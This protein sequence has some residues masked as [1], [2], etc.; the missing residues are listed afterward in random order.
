MGGLAHRA[1]LRSTAPIRDRG[2]ET[3]PLHPAAAFAGYGQAPGC[4]CCS[5]CAWNT[6]GDDDESA[7][8]SFFPVLS[9]SV[10]CPLEYGVIISN[11]QKEKRMSALSE[12][13]S[14]WQ[15]PKASCPNYASAKWPY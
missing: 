6:N 8:I 9:V 14:H 4:L 3:Q 11:D 13:Q 1:P 2:R 15:L 7:L 5:P 12:G 10:A